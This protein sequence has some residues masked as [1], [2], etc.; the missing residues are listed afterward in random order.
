MSTPRLPDPAKLVIG[1]FTQD[2][3]LFDPLATRLTEMFGLTDTISAWMAFDYTDYYEKEMGTPLFRRMMS[4]KTLVKQDQLADIKLKTNALE[5]TY[6]K[7]G[8]RTV[9]LDPG[10]L[11]LSRFVLATGKDFAHR[12]SIGQGI[13]GDL[14]L[15]YKNGGFT[16]LPWTYPDYADKT[17]ISYLLSV[18][19][20]YIH[21]LDTQ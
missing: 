16:T 20:T 1:V 4:F 3:D 5:K 13:Y 11:L 12:I 15:L 2:K 7:I 6:G 17:M 19:N 18:R 21:D 8:H 9:N 14:T 10:Y